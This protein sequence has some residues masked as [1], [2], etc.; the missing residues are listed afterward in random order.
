M[1]GFNEIAGKNRAQM[2]NPKRPVPARERSKRCKLF[3]T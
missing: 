3:A 2:W 1:C